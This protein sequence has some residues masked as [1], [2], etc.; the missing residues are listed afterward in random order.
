MDS[1]EGIAT[2]RTAAHDALVMHYAP[3]SHFQVL[4]VVETVDGRFYAGSN[5]ETSVHELTVH[6]EEN[7]VMAALRGGVLGR[8]GPKCI[9]TVYTA[10]PSNGSLC[11]RCRQVISEFAADDCLWIE[12]DTRSSDISSCKFA[13]LPEYAPDVKLP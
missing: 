6:A 11:E 12:E 3:Y 1:P 10:C 4:A 2:L 9:K 7:A 5:V 8:C 13:E